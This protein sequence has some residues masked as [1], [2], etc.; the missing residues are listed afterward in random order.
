MSPARREPQV[1]KLADSCARQ[2]LE[3][4]PLVMRVIRQE[5]RG[6]GTA[7]LSVPQFR[8][9]AFLGRHRGASL[10]VVAEHLGIADATAS[11]MVER[12]VQRG[13]VSRETHPQERRRV[14]IDL[15]TAGAALLREARERARAYLAASLTA[16]QA[17]SLERLGKS[18]E[19]LR[20]VLGPHRSKGAP[21]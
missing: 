2:L 17:S 19:L 12:L 8:V 4:V 21:P 15:T 16:R 14:V 18:L 6:S 7:S 13:F 11:A 5:M 10:S 9:L 1:R 3:T 20:Q